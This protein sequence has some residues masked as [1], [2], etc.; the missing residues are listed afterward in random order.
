M[1]VCVFFVFAVNPAW[2]TRTRDTLARWRPSPTT[3]PRA[4]ATSPTTFSRLPSTGPWS[5]GRSRRRSPSIRSKRST[6]TSTTSNGRPTIPPSSPRS[7]DRQLWL[8]EFEPGDWGLFRVISSSSPPTFPSIALFIL[9]IPVRKVP[10]EGSP[11]AS[12]LLWTPSG[13]QILVGDNTGKMHVYD[14]K[15]VDIPFGNIQW[16]SFYR[17]YST[18]DTKEER[19]D[20]T[21]FG[22]KHWRAACVIKYWVVA[23]TAQM[24]CHCFTPNAVSS[25]LTSFVLYWSRG[26]Q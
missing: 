5:S 4:T 11:S 26:V 13:Q 23:T 12:R 22:V 16:H 17:E 19:W 14:V 15:E 2:W 24:A 25:H 8:L 6:T 7:T 9:K 20:E 10:L 21:A 3:R 1:C 18:Q